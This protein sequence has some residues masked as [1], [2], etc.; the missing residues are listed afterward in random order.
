M[1]KSKKFNKKQAIKFTLVN[2]KDENGNHI[3][4]FKPI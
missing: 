3:T 4:I 1:K 2:G